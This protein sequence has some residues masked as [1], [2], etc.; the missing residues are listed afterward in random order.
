M[1]RALNHFHNS[2]F[3]ALEP[4]TVP[5]MT[6]LARFIFAAT[7]LVYYWNSG[8][9]KVG[10]GLAGVF[11]PADGAYIQILPKTVEAAGYDY[12]QLTAIHWLIVTAGTWAEFILPL[13]IVQAFHAV[14]GARYDRVCCRAKLG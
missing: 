12:S 8:L 3:G 5:V 13:M 9:T 2:V 6:T 14:G 7:L 10:E 1:I 11:R 4:L